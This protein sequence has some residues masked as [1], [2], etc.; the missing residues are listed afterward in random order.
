MKLIGNTYGDSVDF[1][2]LQQFLICLINAACVYTGAALYLT[3]GVIQTVYGKFDTMNRFRLFGAVP[4]IFIISLMGC[5]VVGIILRY[6]QIGRRIFAIGS[7]EKA[8]FL[9]G[10]KVT[11]NKLIFFALNGF[12]VGLAAVL[13]LSRVGSALPSTGAGYELQAMG[14]V[15]IGG[16]PINGGKG[17]IVGTFFGVLLMGLISNVLNILG[18]NSY[19]QEIASGALIIISLGISA[20]RV[21]MLTKN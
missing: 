5:V 11:R 8:A 10:I 15:V 1:F 18:V 21:H 17:N 16:A 7:N 13:L 9:S 19:L 2:I 12:F 20:I 6:T 3:K 14:A 4:L